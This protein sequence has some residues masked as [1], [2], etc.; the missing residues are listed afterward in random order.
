MPFP[1]TNQPFSLKKTR[2]IRSTHHLFFGFAQNHPKTNLF[3]N[4]LH[5]TVFL[6]ARIAGKWIVKAKKFSIL[7]KFSRISWSINV[8]QVSLER[9]L[10]GLIVGITNPSHEQGNLPSVST[11]NSLPTKYE[12]MYNLKKLSV[13]NKDFYFRSPFFYPFSTCRPRSC[14]CATGVR[15]MAVPGNLLSAAF[16][17]PS[18]RPAWEMRFG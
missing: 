7:H 4:P 2:W 13:W 1:T 17:L 15:A 11:G 3:L 9:I 8:L 18:Q 14:S 12:R 10:I 5:K 16:N 6:R